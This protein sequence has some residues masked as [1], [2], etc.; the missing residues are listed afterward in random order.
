MTIN[1]SELVSNKQINLFAMYHV[2][3]I[4]EN[5]LLQNKIKNFWMVYLITKNTSRKQTTSF[6]T[7][8]YNFPFPFPFIDNFLPQFTC[9]YG[10][11][12]WIK[13][14]LFTLPLGW[15]FCC[16]AP[17]LI[18][19]S[20]KRFWHN[21]FFILTMELLALFLHQ[22]LK[23]FTISKCMDL[24]RYNCVYWLSV[25]CYTTYIQIFERK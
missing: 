7:P 18:H 24:F 15:I 1:A 4:C 6:V 3:D 10:V 16:S 23:L 25:L 14:T 12:E 17:I 21:H 20:G 22:N 11:E 5:T 2:E 9:R 8:E 13:P 19:L